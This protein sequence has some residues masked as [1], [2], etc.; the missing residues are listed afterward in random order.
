MRDAWHVMRETSHVIIN[1]GSL[2][3]T[4]YAARLAYQSKEIRRRVDLGMRT[5]DGRHLDA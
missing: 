3:I 1:L 5:Q 2:R 4:H